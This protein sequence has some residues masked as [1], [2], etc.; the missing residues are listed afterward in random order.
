MFPSRIS[1]YDLRN[2]N[3]FERRRVKSAWCMLLNRYR[4]LI[5]KSGTQVPNETKHTA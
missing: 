3:I 5:K 2:N 4:F 1:P